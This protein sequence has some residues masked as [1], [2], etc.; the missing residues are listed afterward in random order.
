MH[1]TN[2]FYK[3]K[4]YS[5]KTW[6]H[7]NDLISSR[8]KYKQHNYFKTNYSIL[9]DHTDI[10]DNF[11]SYFTNIGPNLANKIQNVLPINPL[12]YLNTLDNNVF[13]FQYIDE[14]I[15]E[16]IIDNFPSKNS[17]GYDGISLRL[18][19]FCKLTII[20]PL[21]LII[22]QVLNTGIL[23]EKL[24]IAKV[25]PIFKKGDEE[26]FSNYRPIFIS[27]AISKIIEK[28]IYQHIYSV[29]FN[30]MNF[31]TAVNMVSELI[32]PLNMLHWN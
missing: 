15:V 14:S 9:T 31:F 20:K 13:H 16:Q 8:N 1:Y 32:I 24:K 21:M 17:C 3:S 22:R 4:N 5:K 23:P 28:V 18:L 26:L 10:A 30:R 19:K 6:K 11:N 25:I 29:F 27:P 2:M 12:S 7:I